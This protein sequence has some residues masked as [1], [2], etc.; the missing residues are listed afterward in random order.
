MIMNVWRQR[1]V[2]D[3]THGR[4]STPVGWIWT[5]ALSALPAIGTEWF[6]SADGDNTTYTN[7]AT[8]AHTIQAAVDAA[9]YGDTVW[10]TNGT[11]TGTG[12]E[13]VLLQNK[14]TALR[15]VNGCLYTIINGGNARRGIRMPHNEAYVN[16][17][18][19]G[20]TV[21]NCN[22]GTGGSGGGAYLSKGTIQN[23]RFTKNTADNHGGGVFAYASGATI[24]NCVIVG[25]KTTTYSGGGVTL[26]Y[27]CVAENCLIAGN[28]AAYLGG[29]IWPVGG[30]G[31]RNCTIVGNTSADNRGSGVGENDNGTTYL[32]NCIVW[33][34]TGDEDIKNDN[35][36]LYIQNCCVK[37]ITGGYGAGGVSNIT[38][39]PRFVSA[40][41]GDYR[42]GS[43]SPCVDKGR[44]LAMVTSD[45]NGAPRPLDG[46]GDGIA[47]YDMGVYEIPVWDQYYVSPDGDNTA[48]TNWAT[49]AHSIQAAVDAAPNNAT[50]WVTNGTYTGTGAEVVLLQNKNTALRSVNGFLY[51]I[52]NG[53][54]ARRGIRMP[55][56]EAYVNGIVDGFTVTNCNCGA[57]ESGGGAYLSKGTIQNCRFTKNTAVN[58]GGGVFVNQSGATIR[59]CVIVGNKTTTYS[60]G[61][62]TLYYGCVAENCL[63]AGNTAALLGG[64]IWPV[65]GSGVRN[66]TIVG[67]T[68]ADTRGSGVGENDY[69]I[70]YLQNCIVWDNTGDEDIKNDNGKLYIQNCCVKSITGSYGAGGVSNITDNPRFVNAAGGDYRLRSS[71]PCVDKGMTLAMVTNDLDGA[72]RPMDGNWNGTAEYDIGAY[73]LPPPA[74]GTAILIR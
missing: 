27:D 1:A 10:V 8:A 74:L 28:T 52:I 51:T 36:K 46:N 17:I 66:C 3:R 5:L 58:H 19:D 34:N 15:S 50:V 13:V 37:S 42:L 65:G 12:A 14:N 60:G 26:Y 45:L 20:F 69:S 4:L 59:N 9:G 35:G 11:Y 53:E 73:E 40:A 39:N 29:G 30:S 25:N 2:R 24:R 57:G 67:N 22:C 16:G 72:S 68:S 33:D 48:F 21:T 31:V 44:T 32:Q 71:S 18:V 64:G 63:I 54:N 62:V 70:S 61:G 41:G 7:W 38:D 43:S 55:H 47:E 56:N 49:A 23:C 6:V